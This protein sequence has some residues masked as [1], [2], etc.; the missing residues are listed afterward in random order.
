L[1]TIEACLAVRLAADGNGDGH[2]DGNGDEPL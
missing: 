2:G 1:N